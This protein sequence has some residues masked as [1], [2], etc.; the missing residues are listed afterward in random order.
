MAKR[1]RG[2]VKP[3]GA[4]GCARQREK[5]VHGCNFFVIL[6]LTVLELGAYKAVTN[7]G[8]APLAARDCC[9]CFWFGVFLDGMRCINLKAAFATFDMA[10]VLSGGLCHWVWIGVLTVCRLEVVFRRFFD[11]WIMGKRNVGGAGRGPVWPCA[12]PV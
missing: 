8:G 9:P 4:G 5:A 10:S 11:N 6:G 12:D 3:C 7:E 2:C 1:C